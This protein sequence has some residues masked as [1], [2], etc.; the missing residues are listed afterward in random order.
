[1]SKLA[2]QDIHDGVVGCVPAVGE[3]TAFEEGHILIG[4][5]LPELVKKPGFADACLG[6][7]GDGLASAFSGPFK[8]IQEEVQAPLPSNEGCQ[9]SFRAD[10]E[11][12]SPGT[13]SNDL[14]DPDGLL[15]PLDLPL[16]QGLHTE[17]ALR[18]PEC[19]RG[20]IG[21]PRFG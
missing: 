16:P 3:A 15:L 9:S 20:D 4:N 14:V 1:M 12:G 17:Q 6:D 11:P 19:V 8:T 13:G 21:C 10:I 5:G 2:F 7:D 18:D